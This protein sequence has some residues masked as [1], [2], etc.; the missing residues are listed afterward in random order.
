MP[1]FQVT[2]TLELPDRQHFVLAGSVVE[3]EIRPGM[4]VNVPI[5]EF[6]TFRAPILEVGTTTRSGREDLC[7]HLEPELGRALREDGVEIRDQTVEITP[8][9]IKPKG[10]LNLYDPYESHALAEQ[11]FKCSQCGSLLELQCNQDE[12]VGEG[13]SALAENAKRLGWFVPAAEADGT[14]D[15]LTCYCPACGQCKGADPPQR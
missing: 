12:P 6:L 7:L 2:D 3:G 8:T 4:W 10:T 1:K 11:E 13:L 5:S 9:R 14:L 15:L